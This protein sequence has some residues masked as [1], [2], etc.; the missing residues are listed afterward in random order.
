MPDDK[1][2]PFKMSFL[3]KG[4][5]EVKIVGKQTLAEP[6]TVLFLSSYFFFIAGVN[7]VILLASIFAKD[8]LGFESSQ[9]ILLI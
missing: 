9:L 3:K 1:T 7:V 5:D 6:N 4:F 2:T 8:E